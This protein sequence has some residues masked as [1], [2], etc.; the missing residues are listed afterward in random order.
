MADNEEDYFSVS[1]LCITV[2]IN[3]AMRTK[4]N[5]DDDVEC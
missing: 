5:D 1:Y 3:I 2:N 4:S